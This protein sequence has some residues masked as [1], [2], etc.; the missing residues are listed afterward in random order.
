M[1]LI[2]N[3][4]ILAVLAAALSAWSADEPPATAGT[5]NMPNPPAEPAPVTAL[6]K[7]D[8]A[9]PAAPENIA[10][11]DGSLRLNFRGA[12]LNLVLDYLSDAAGFVINKETEV[13]GTVEVW[14][15]DPVS[16]DEAVEILN[17]VLRKNGYA[18]IRN[19][20]ILTIV[21]LDT[22]K[23]AD[24]PVDIGSNADEV[25]RSDEIVTQIIPVRHASAS[26]L[27]NNLQ[28]LLPTTATLSVNESAN[29]LIL[30]ATKTDI[31]RMLRIVTA[32]D[33]SISS[34]SSIKVFPLRYAD[35]RQLATVVQQLFAPQ[36]SAQAGGGGRGQL[37]NM[38][39]GGGPFGQGG[40]GGQQAGGAGTG[41]NAAG[42]RVVAA[43]DEYSNSLIV[44]AAADLMSTISDMVEQVDQPVSDVTEVRVFKLQNADPSELADQ[45]AQ[46]FPDDTRSGSN[47]QGGG[48]RF[49]FFGGGR[50]GGAASTQAGST[51]RTKKKSKVV[52]VADPRTRSLIVTAAAEMMP[53]IA[54]MVAQLDSSDARKERVAVFDLQNANPQDVYEIM[55]DLF[56]RNNTMRA[57]NNNQ[58]SMLGRNNPLTQRSTQQQQQNSSGMNSR[59][60]SGNRT[61]GGF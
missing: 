61:S 57:N 2:Q 34:V 43:A 39:R 53:Q 8:Q 6:P 21:G 47:N 25:E 38:F 40:P 4:L 11:T 19:G 56:N 54:E 3:P 42:S 33:T 35:A 52:A 22:A 29:S 28:V 13:R 26:Q 60:G 41:G 58:N 48:G 37:F 10:P 15:K 31:R 30:V 49:Q 18:V 20:R 46:L 5:N 14:S 51:D 27:M 9:A 24:L 55:Q 36:T 59:F 1:K 16:K 23:T 44:S 12:P 17:S 7:T 45:F 50:F 32:L